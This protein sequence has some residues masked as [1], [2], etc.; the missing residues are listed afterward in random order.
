[1]YLLGLNPALRLTDLVGEF[2]G[3][4]ELQDDQHEL[5]P[6]THLF[7][8][9]RDV[10]G[11]DDVVGFDPPG[12]GLVKVS[13]LVALVRTPG[14]EPLPARVVCFLVVHA[15]GGQVVHGGGGTG[16]CRQNGM[17]VSLEKR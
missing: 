1:M 17:D 5:E 9:Q 3:N 14:H 12:H 10:N 11:E 4:V 15:L 2:E 6:G 8:G 7:I 16:G 13:N